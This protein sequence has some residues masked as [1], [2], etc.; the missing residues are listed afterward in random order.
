MPTRSTFLIFYILL[1]LQLAYGLLTWYLIYL[2]GAGKNGLG[3]SE[4]IYLPALLI[5]L[6]TAAA[7]FIDRSRASQAKRYQMN[8][9]IGQNRYRTT[10]LLR[11]SLIQAA[12]LM[13]LTLAL[14]A[15]RMDVM[16]LLLPGLLV[17]MFFRPTAVQFN[18]RYV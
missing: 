4:I 7:W 13:A 14:S 17:F 16:T 18:N 11:L 10:V 12:N 9:S 3:G 6:S 2:Q 8:A 5:V 15:R 1:F